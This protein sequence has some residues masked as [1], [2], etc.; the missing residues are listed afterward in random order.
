MNDPGLDDAVADEAN[1]LDLP[2]SNDK[3]ISSHGQDPSSPSLDSQQSLW[4]RW[5]LASTAYPLIA[6]T[7]GPM[8]SAFNICSLA[9]PWRMNLI[10]GGSLD[11]PDPKW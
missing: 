3:N 6:G 5:W 7:F 9:Q 2:E 1:A 10:T 4:G 8:A 11:I